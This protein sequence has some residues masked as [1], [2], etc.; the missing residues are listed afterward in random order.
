MIQ[1][2][3]PADGGR[4]FASAHAMPIA[5]SLSHIDLA[6]SDLELIARVASMRLDEP[7]GEMHRVALVDRIRHKAHEVARLLHVWQTQVIVECRGTRS[8]RDLST[9]NRLY[10]ETLAEYAA[11]VREVADSMRRLVARSGAAAELES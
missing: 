10:V 7:E 4:A 6:P 9:T 2:R 5:S 3:R 8:A 1:T 11:M